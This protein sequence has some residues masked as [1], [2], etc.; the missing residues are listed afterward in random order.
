MGRI[1]GVV[2][3][4]E[5]DAIDNPLGHDAQQTAGFQEA[6]KAIEFKTWVVQVFDDFGGGYEVV[7]AGEYRGLAG[8][9]RIVEGDVVAGLRQH[10]RER[11]AGSRAEIQ[12]LA[13]GGQ[14]CLQWKKQSVQK[15][16]VARIVRSVLVP[17]VFGFFFCLAEIIG[18][19]HKHQAAGPAAII[20][21]SLI[22]VIKIVLGVA[23]QGATRSVVTW[24]Q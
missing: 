4:G 12:P 14:A 8:I 10:D 13:S 21:S 11:R 22:L 23:A 19:R 5:P 24:F 3:G 18:G 20:S 16:A 7:T 9:K 1:V 17:I 15:L 6:V 2:P